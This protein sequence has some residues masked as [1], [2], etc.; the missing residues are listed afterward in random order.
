MCFKELPLF[1]VYE[2]LPA[3]LKEDVRSLELGLDSCEPWRS[4]GCWKSNLRLLPGQHVLLLC[5]E[6]G[7]LPE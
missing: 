3:W 6:E 7:G 5:V 4:T 1:Y 2:C